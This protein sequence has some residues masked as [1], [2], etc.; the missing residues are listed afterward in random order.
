VTP[1][2]TIPE[3]VDAVA[4]EIVDSAF[5]VHQT[6][7]PGLLE[8]TYE[9][10]LRHELTKRGR[11]ARAQVPISIVYDG[12]RLEVGFRMD[13]LVDECVVVELKAIDRLAPV[14]EAQ[15]LTYLRLSRMRLGLLVNFNV[16][17]IKDG[18]R[19]FAL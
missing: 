19:R 3:D 11:S 8:S 6:L 15:M 16:V 12:V 4:R 10:C 5:R 9:A 1:G 2:L 14:V 7:G 17:R 13:L 18:I